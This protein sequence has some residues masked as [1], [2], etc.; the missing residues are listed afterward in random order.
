M[1]DV[2]KAKG[3]LTLGSRFRRLG[4][5]LQAEVQVMAGHYGLDLPSSLFTTMHTIDSH[6]T[7]TVGELAQ[8]LGISQ[9][10][11][12]RTISQ[13]EKLGLVTVK[14]SKEDRRVRHI[15]LTRKCKLEVDRASTE[16]WPR[17]ERAVA[18]ICEPLKRG[19]LLDMLSAIEG[20]LDEKPL[21]QRGQRKTEKAK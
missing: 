6:G 18:E 19:G 5:R 8:A 7:I 4:E 13:M 15:A 16:F 14:P 10:G 2:V 12:T 21:A 17:V 3:Y 9:P 20:A 11:V 1:E